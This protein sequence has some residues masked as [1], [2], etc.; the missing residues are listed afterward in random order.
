MGHPFAGGDQRWRFEAS[1]HLCSKEHVSDK[2]G[3]G[4]STELELERKENRQMA[5][6]S[7]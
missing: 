3:E 4:S 2:R 6:R 5:K 1:R 7:G